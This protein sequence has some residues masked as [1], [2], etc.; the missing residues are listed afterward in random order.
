MREEKL[1]EVVSFLERRTRKTFA[2]LA[3]PSVLSV[4]SVHTVTRLREPLFRD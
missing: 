2:H 1:R 3:V 4:G